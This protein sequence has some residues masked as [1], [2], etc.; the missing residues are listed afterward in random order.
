M[1]ILMI[2]NMP[3]TMEGTSGKHTPQD[4]LPSYDATCKFSILTT[5]EIIHPE[6]ASSHCTDSIVLGEKDT[7]FPRKAN[8]YRMR[9][10]L[11]DDEVALP[12]SKRIHRSLEAI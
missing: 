1:L 2:L 4:A 11:V 3:K 12:A 8:K 7:C 6:R 9:R 10:N 5:S